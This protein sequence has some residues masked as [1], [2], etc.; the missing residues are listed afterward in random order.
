M[1]LLGIAL[2]AG[3]SYAY[4]KA[5]KLDLFNGS[6][7][8]SAYSM[9]FN[10]TAPTINVGDTVNFSYTITPPFPST[11]LSP[12][13]AILTSI[14]IDGSE[15]G[16]TTSGVTYADSGGDNNQGWFTLTFNSAGTHAVEYQISAIYG[17][18]SV[19][20]LS[21]VSTVTVNTPPVNEALTVEATAG[22]NVLLYSSTGGTTA[23]G[24]LG[25]VVGGET[26]TFQIQ[27]Y[28]QVD[29]KETAAPNYVFQG[30]IFPDGSVQ[31][32]NVYSTTLSGPETVKAVFS[33]QGELTVTVIGGGWVVLTPA[34]T[35][36]QATKG[37]EQANQ[38]TTSYMYTP[39][40]TVTLQEYSDTT[41]WQFTGWNGGSTAASETWTASTADALY[42]AT[43][44]Q[45]QPTPT[46]T[47]T[48]PGST[49]TPTPQTTPTPTPTLPALTPTPTPWIP[50]ST[51]PTPSSGPNTLTLTLNANPMECARI[52]VQDTNGASTSYTSF[53]ATFVFNAGDVITVQ[54]Y[55]QAGYS[56][57]GWTNNGAASSS[58]A[59]YTFTVNGN[60]ALTASF[61]T[62][63]PNSPTPPPSGSPTPTPTATV[64]PSS[65]FTLTVLDKELIAAAGAI[66][67]AAGAA[68]I[69]I[70]RKL[71]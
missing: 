42:T 70:S 66:L 35:A 50:P 59:S 34:D 61:M 45:V 3:A 44:V 62:S 2:I 11:P 17:G 8:L 19:G 64:A 68:T 32:G 53:P 67:T 41:R 52:A 39:G 47:A 46:P 63:T 1:M 40:T 29:M 30:W 9:I 4:L 5:P 27:Q 57:S 43:F 37:S 16:S 48:P 23:P 33:Q 65:S 24:S 28:T 6:G 51:T 15:L 25:S 22:G 20:M 31:G 21:G 49:P 12:G 10:P 71:N 54:A 58:S 60:T 13:Y 56:F 38:G 69:A 55:A 18:P 7:Q 36:D 14:W 26:E